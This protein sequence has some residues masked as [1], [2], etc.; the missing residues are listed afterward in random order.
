MDGC[1]F[2]KIIDAFWE[3]RNMGVTCTEV[4]IE[5]FDTLACLA[6]VNEIESEYQVVK[7]PPLKVD[8]MHG[9]EDKGFR[10]IEGIL[11][12]YHN[13]KNLESFRIGVVARIVEE[14]E[15]SAMSYDDLDELFAQIRTG[16]FKV[17][18]V[19]IDSAFTAEQSA[20]RYIG[21]IND[22]L[23]HG[24]TVYKGTIGKEAF[25]FF[26]LLKDSK[27]IAHSSITSV[28]NGY[29]N[30][31]L[32]LGLYYYMAYEAAQLGCK[33]MTGSGVAVSSNNIN[34]L[35]ALLAVG[36]QVKHITYVY[37]KHK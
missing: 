23:T 24:A 29:E 37:V 9:L 5:S 31:G 7:C 28:Y 33:A 4:L 2:M 15:Y 3:K 20:N 26:T 14:T 12:L 18:R 21:W 17:D 13:L 6:L 30:T 35:R 32:G 25:G 16:I 34:S 19:S 11:E 27:N 36:F 10:F 1:A 22:E 8:I